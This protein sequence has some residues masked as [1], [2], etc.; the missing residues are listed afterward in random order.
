VT[1]PVL[2][3]FGTRPEVVKLAPVVHELRRR[4]VPVVVATTG[5]H[6][7]MLAQMLEDFELEPDVDCALM[8]PG[9][10]LSDLTGR[11]VAALG[12][13]VRAAGP[14]AVVVQ[15]DTTTAFCGALAA[16]YEQV[17]VA[18]VEAGLRTGDVTN[19]F[20]EEA[21]RRLVAQLARWHF[22][23]TETSRANLLREGFA[24]AAV[25]VTGNT[26][27]DAVTWMAD[28]AP[29]PAPVTGRRVLVTMHRRESQG[30]AQRAIS[31]ML[32][33]LADRDDVHVVFPVHL[34]PAVRASVLP[35]LW[36][37]PSVTLR[38]PLGYAEFVGELAAADLVLSDSGGVQEE[39][40][41]LDV[42]VLVMRETTERPEGVAAGCAVL[43]GTDPARILGEAERVLDDP[44]AHARMAAALNPYG[45]GRAAKAVVDRLVTELEDVV[46]P[47]AA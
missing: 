19:P 28:R 1:R 39:A 41:A 38:E 17:P 23:P 9:Q 32:A 22:C 3:C 12:E 29:R 15:G 43:C 13:V 8:Q 42:P 30:D 44:L 2:V 26:T 25:S 7:E 24:P 20:P 40:P 16:F 5:Q 27:I 46:L 4:A 21:N 37:H 45:D 34:S 35:E 36:G 18:H 33:R 31:R 11:A 6:R 47:V 14:A 10:A